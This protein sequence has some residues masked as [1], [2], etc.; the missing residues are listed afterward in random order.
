M[1][2]KTEKPF[3]LF[4]PP[5]TGSMVC[6][7]REKWSEERASGRCGDYIL[8]NNYTLLLIIV[9]QHHIYSTSQAHY[10][11]MIVSGE[12]V[13]GEVEVKSLS[14]SIL[15]SPEV[16]GERQHAVLRNEWIASISSSNSAQ[17]KGAV[18]C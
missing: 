11:S 18:P 8:R 14:L 4:H 15:N 16:V 17:R 9:G 3:R 5:T 7:W 12:S 1:E 13:G 6:V 2:G 10:L